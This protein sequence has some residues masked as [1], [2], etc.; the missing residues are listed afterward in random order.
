MI[1][2]STWADEIRPSRPQTA[3]WHYVN[4]EI[5]STGYGAASDCPNVACVVAWGCHSGNCG[6]LWACKKNLVHETLGIRFLNVRFAPGAA[7]PA[8]AQSGFSAGDFIDRGPVLLAHALGN[9]YFHFC[10]G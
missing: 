4:I 2:A 8:S 1:R 7:N 9:R 3:P 6:R 5:T 10:L